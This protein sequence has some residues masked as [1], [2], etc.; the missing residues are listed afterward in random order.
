MKTVFKLNDVV[1]LK[2]G[3]PNMLVQRHTCGKVVCYYWQDENVFKSEV[4]EEDTL[5]LVNGGE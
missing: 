3:G 2:S 1:R 4:F 5:D